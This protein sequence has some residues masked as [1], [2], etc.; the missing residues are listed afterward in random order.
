MSWPTRPAPAR[1]LTDKEDTQLHLTDAQRRALTLLA[2]RPEWTARQFA[3]QMW[4]DADGWST[5][6]NAG[7]HGSR[8][9]AGMWRAGGA[10]LSK[11]AKTGL[12]TYRHTKYWQR[13]YSLTALGREVIGLTI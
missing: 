6:S 9:G 2:T 12:A 11:L 1:P 3:E 8:R 4:P 10:Y 5:V 7:T 13:L